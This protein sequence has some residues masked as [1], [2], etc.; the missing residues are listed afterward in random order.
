MAC[1]HAH[2][3]EPGMLIGQ[4]VFFRHKKV[5]K[6]ASYAQKGRYNGQTEV[7]ASKG[8]Q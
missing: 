5:P 2:T 7:T 3:L 8:I 6:H 4:V 1:R